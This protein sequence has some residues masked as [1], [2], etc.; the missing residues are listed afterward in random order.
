[1]I[2]DW[3]RENVIQAH[4]NQRAHMFYVLDGLTDDELTKE[5]TTE[6]YSR[7]IAGIVMHIGT[8]ETYWFHKANE[9]IGPPT[10]A[11]TFAEVKSLLQENT[12]KI[13]EKIRTCP[14]GK[15]RII[16]PK[17]GGP[18][19]A[20]AVLR[21]AQHGIYHNG[22]IAKIRRMIG[23]SELSPDSEDLWGKAVDSLI[24]IIRI[25]I[26]DDPQI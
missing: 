8:A 18:S 17:E 25:L 16:P 9:S 7:S 21:T 13:M 20:W 26:E 1:M 2:P 4:K 22:Q 19:I 3:F 5:V 24:G 14:D 10:I 23:A 12:E 6:E 15:M 11:D